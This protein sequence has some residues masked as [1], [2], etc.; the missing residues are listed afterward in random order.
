[1]ATTDPIAPD[2]RTEILVTLAEVRGQVTQALTYISTHDGRIVEIESRLRA[3]ENEQAQIKGRTAV[4]AVVA[5]AA[6]SLIVAII[7]KLIGA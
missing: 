1:M 7:T 4:L 6:I 5:G 2:E 3:V